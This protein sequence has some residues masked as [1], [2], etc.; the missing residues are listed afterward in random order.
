M[1]GEE[2]LEEAD[3]FEGEEAT[4]DLPLKEGVVGRHIVAHF[5]KL[6]LVAVGAKSLGSQG[7]GQQD[8]EI[9][10]EGGLVQSYRVTFADLLS[11]EVV[12]ATPLN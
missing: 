2:Y 5:E 7:E 11:P 10:F 3:Y 8:Y 9:T 12:D 6:G 1:T 4:E